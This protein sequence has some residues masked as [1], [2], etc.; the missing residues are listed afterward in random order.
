MKTVLGIDLA[1][2]K[3]DVA[4]DKYYGLLK[5]D[6]MVT[7]ANVAGLS[8]EIALAKPYLADKITNELLKFDSL[9]L[10]THVTEEC[11]RVIDEKA[12]KSFDL[13]FDKITQKKNVISFA[14]KHIDS[15]RKTLRVTAESFLK[16][17]TLDAKTLDVRTPKKNKKHF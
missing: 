7:I 13:F 12:I 5:D 3:F 1:K 17:H 4:F 9:P 2:K 15:P 11:K 14:K 8:G 6:Y 10:T 16:K